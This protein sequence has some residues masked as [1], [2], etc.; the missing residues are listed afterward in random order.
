[1]ETPCL[2]SPE[3]SRGENYRCTRKRRLRGP[4]CW[5]ST[6]CRSEN[7]GNSFAERVFATSKSKFGYFAS[8][9]KRDKKFRRDRA[10][11]EEHTSELQS[12]PHL[13]CRLLLEKKK[14]Q[15]YSLMFVLKNIL[16]CHY[17]CD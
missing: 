2:F 3:G 8:Y 10:R 9:T 4:D 17:V 6:L 14:Q 5:D 1:M 11:S 7:G 15:I 16:N 12:R 13:V